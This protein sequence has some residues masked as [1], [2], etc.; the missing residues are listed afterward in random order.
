MP[1]RVLSLL[2]IIVCFACCANKKEGELYIKEYK[3]SLEI[4]RFLVEE[5]K[6]AYAQFAEAGLGAV[7]NTYDVSLQNKAKT[8]FAFKTA[9]NDMFAATSEPYNMQARGDYNESIEYNYDLFYKALATQRPDMKIDTA[10]LTVEISGRIFKRMK[11]KGIYPDN[12]VKYTITYSHLYNNN[13]LTVSIMYDDVE[14]GEL[15]DSA[16]KKSKFD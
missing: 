3:W 12:T 6:D 5:N 1:T 7:E 4:P 8:L 11:M 2:T 16:F 9:D 10:K 13:E 15:M 14:K